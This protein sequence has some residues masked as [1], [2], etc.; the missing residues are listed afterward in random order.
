MSVSY[1]GYASKTHR[2]RIVKKQDLGIYSKKGSFACAFR[3][4]SPR[5]IWIYPFLLKNYQVSFHLKW[6]KNQLKTRIMLKPVTWLSLNVKWLASVGL[7]ISLKAAIVQTVKSP[8][9]LKIVKTVLKLLKPL[10]KILF[11]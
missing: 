11:P 3:F 4:H 6:Q 8:E 7:K 10:L 5:N 2:G 1:H 9:L